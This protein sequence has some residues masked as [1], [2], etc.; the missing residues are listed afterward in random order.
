[1]ANDFRRV[2]TT[3]TVKFEQVGQGWKALFGEK[4]IAKIE[5]KELI[6][7]IEKGRMIDD[8]KEKH[9]YAEWHTGE[10]L[11]THLTLDDAKKAIEMKHRV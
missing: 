7:E 3:L 4:Q 6:V 8:I 9:Y 10:D 1:M 11:G 5:E 2:D